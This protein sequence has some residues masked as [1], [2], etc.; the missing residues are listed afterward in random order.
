ML[1]AC[2]GSGEGRGPDDRRS[3]Q[4]CHLCAFVFY[5]GRIFSN[6][7]G[8]FA[9][10]FFRLLT[11]FIILPTL[12]YVLYVYYMCIICVLY[13]VFYSLHFAYIIAFCVPNN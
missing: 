10:H 12:Y 7:H 6:F 13:C 5:V 2:V 4:F 3:W 1:R 8:N 9:V 11:L